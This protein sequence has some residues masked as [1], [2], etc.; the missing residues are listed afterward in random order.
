M[1]KHDNLNPHAEARLAMVLW[2]D[3]YSD[4]PGGCMDFWDR[5]EPSEQDLCVRL[6]DEIFAAAEKN[7]RAVLR[8]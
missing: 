2:S 5:L 4:Q 3:D 6:V 8:R 7:G 1:Q